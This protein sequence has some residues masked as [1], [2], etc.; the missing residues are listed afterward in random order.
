W[1]PDGRRLAYISERGSRAAKSYILVIRSTET[2][3][4]REFHELQPNMNSV[5]L[6]SWAPG[7]RFLLL[8]GRDVKG[9][10]AF[11]L[12]DAETGDVKTV[13]LDSEG[14]TSNWAPDGRFFLAE[15]RGSKPGL[16]R[17]DVESG[18]AVEVMPIPPGQGS[19]GLYPLMS[20]DGKSFYYLRVF[21]AVPR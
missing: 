4:V 13:G 3:Q 7:G 15:V 9:R 17:V 6:D 10:W 5:S 11:Y 14:Y 16:Y 19:E 20:A 2:G 8:N 18:N 1:S 21:K 12:V